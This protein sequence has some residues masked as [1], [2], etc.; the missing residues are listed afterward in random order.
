[1]IN[2]AT[3]LA[4]NKARTAATFNRPTKA[5]FDA[6]ESGHSSVATLAPYLIAAAGGIPL[7]V[8]GKVIGGI[9]VSGSPT[10]LLDSIPAQAGADALK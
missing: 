9:G 1:M 3:E 2:A 5:F 8:D 7:M 6:M 4:I 10:G